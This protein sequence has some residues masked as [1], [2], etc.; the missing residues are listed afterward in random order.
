MGTVGGDGRS[1]C[2][3]ILVRTLL[4]LQEQPQLHRPILN[5]FP[6]TPKRRC[7]GLAKGW[8]TVISGGHYAAAADQ[9][10][11]KLTYMVN[12]NTR[13]PKIT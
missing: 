3:G 5:P 2:A 13:N 6:N 10:L 9:I 4:L 7:A 8:C 12:S 11:M 1:N